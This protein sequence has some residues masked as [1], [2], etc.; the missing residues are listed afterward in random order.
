MRFQVAWAVWRMSCKEVAS[1]AGLR[2]AEAH[3]RGGLKEE[4]WPMQGRY[5]RDFE[6][7]LAGFESGKL[8]RG[9]VTEKRLPLVLMDVATAA[10][11]VETHG[12]G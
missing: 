3:G 4:T 5:G 2:T 9:C 6:R 10:N 7:S 1:V 12:R 11:S 8:N